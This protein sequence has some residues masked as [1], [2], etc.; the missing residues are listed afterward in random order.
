MT[1][2]AIEALVVRLYAASGGREAMDV[3]FEVY[4]DALDLIPDAVGEEAG[5]YLTKTVDLVQHRSSP[6]M[7]RAQAQVILQRRR[8]AVSAIPEATGTPVSREE[9]LEWVRKIREEHGPSPM[10]TDALEGV[11]MR[12][13]SADA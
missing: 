12:Q 7:V 9:S 13:P 11:A 6:G 2:G 1:P 10:M 3:D 5:R 8:D 4:A